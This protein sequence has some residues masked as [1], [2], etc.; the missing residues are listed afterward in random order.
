MSKGSM[1]DLT[2]VLMRGDRGLVLVMAGGGAWRL[3]PPLLC[4][5]ERMLGQRVRVIG[6]RSGFDLIDARTI[7]LLS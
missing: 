5:T 4:R 6:T 2:G 3:D 1:Y 7:D